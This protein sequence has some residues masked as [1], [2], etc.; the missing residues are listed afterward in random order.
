MLKLKATVRAHR[1]PERVCIVAAIGIVAAPIALEQL[2]V[3]D[4]IL[5]VPGAL[6]LFDLAIPA[7]LQYCALPKHHKDLAGRHANSNL[8]KSSRIKV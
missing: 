6:L 4:S 3:E 7:P 5:D 2:H 1:F 8:Q